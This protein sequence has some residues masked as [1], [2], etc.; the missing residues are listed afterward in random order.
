MWPSVALVLLVIAGGK[1]MG[2]TSPPRA[3]RAPDFTLSDWQ[4]N[5]VSLADF[6]GRVI[7]LQFF[8]TGCPVCQRHAPILESLYRKYK[9][10]G[11]VVI[12]VSHD[13]GGPEALKQFVKKFGLTYFVLVGDL[14]IAVRYL[15][16]TPQESSFDIPR[17][18]L[19][20]SEGYIVRDIDPAADKIFV[21]DEKGKIE[22]AILEVFHASLPMHEKSATTSP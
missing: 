1:A 4:G 9:D 13:A 14:E 2:Q 7:L 3:Y 22:Q 17:Y 18:F 6:R 12:G 10:Q 5:K 19:I 8:Q 20:N 15:G 16:I 11:L 21:Q